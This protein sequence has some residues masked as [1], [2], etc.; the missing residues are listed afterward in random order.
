MIAA[1]EEVYGEP[2]RKALPPLRKGAAPGARISGRAA[3]D[4]GCGDGFS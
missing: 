1:I 3:R 2:G 4:V